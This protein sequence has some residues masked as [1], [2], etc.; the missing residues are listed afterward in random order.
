[1][2]NT[3][4]ETKTSSAAVVP[5]KQVWKGHSIWEVLTNSE[6]WNTDRVTCVPQNWTRKQPKT[7][8]KEEDDDD[9]DEEEEDFFNVKLLNV[10]GS[11]KMNDEIAKNQCI[12]I[13]DHKW[14]LDAVVGVPIQP[15]NKVRVSL[16]TWVQGG[17]D[18]DICPTS[19][20]SAG[21]EVLD[22]PT[23]Y[24]PGDVEDIG[25]KDETTRDGVV[26][27]ADPGSYKILKV[28]EGGQLKKHITK[29]P[30]EYGDKE[31]RW[32][33]ERRIGQMDLSNIDITII[34]D[35][36]GDCV[37]EF[38]HGIRNFVVNRVEDAESSGKPLYLCIR[39]K[40]WSSNLTNIRFNEVSL[41]R[42][43]SST[44]ESSKPSESLKRTA[45]ESFDKELG[46]KQSKKET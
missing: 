9:D 34:R 36:K 21:L 19:A 12:V 20:F 3:A 26:F 44:K 24:L 41:E 15:D 32:S 2:M 23:A 42:N 31:P 14:T 29:T 27:N 25:S 7:D 4:D 45:G 6:T 17:G 28:K 39:L 33:W 35:S 18:A 11:G 30:W 43:L 46:A 13:V 8:N 1:M 37:F 16:T 10:P 38:D 22:D 40:G 5:V